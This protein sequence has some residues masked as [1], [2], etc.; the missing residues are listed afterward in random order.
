MTAVQGME[1]LPLRES[2][3]DSSVEVKKKGEPSPFDKLLA[4]D[5]ADSPE[6]ASAGKDPS[7]RKAERPDRNIKPAR[8]E[9]PVQSKSYSLGKI[10]D[11]LKK[12]QEEGLIDTRSRPDFSLLDKKN[13]SFEF[14]PERL[15]GRFKGLAAV[16]NISKSSS[17]GSD[18]MT[19]ISRF[20]KGELSPEELDELVALE[21]KGDRENLL[22]SL[23]EDKFGIRDIPSDEDGS[24]EDQLLK[25]ILTEDGELI[26]FEEVPGDKILQTEKGKSAHLS[27]GEG[28]ANQVQIE[29]NV[30]DLRTVSAEQGAAAAALQEKV[31]HIREAGSGHGDRDSVDDLLA[32]PG[33][34]LFSAEGAGGRFEAPVTKEVSRLF[35]D[36]MNETGNKELVRKIDFILKNDN[37][38]EIKLILKP[39]ALGNVRINLSLNE[40][41][42]A[43][44]IIVDNS[45]VRDIFLNN[46]DQLTSLL[47]NNGYETASLEVW[48]GQDGRNGN[49]QEQGEDR[50]EEKRLRSVK[51]LE[52][53]DESVPQTAYAEGSD[54]GQVNL[55]I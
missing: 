51:G 11:L 54:M 47:K 53:L 43:G 20:L 42:I 3:P 36:Y 37:Q 40:N 12:G 29:I 6:A 5:E 35:R 33:E 15:N 38:G 34:K 4:K 55:V 14:S 44:K 17:D 28:K 30:S 8:A 22:F 27:K 1:M 18:E 39:E 7:A 9:E 45:S 24:G 23:P 10:A 25:G 48:V 49:Q 26:Y 16:Q 32:G 52:R 19:L 46:M 41:H 31:S 2:A 13:V 50:E 21:G